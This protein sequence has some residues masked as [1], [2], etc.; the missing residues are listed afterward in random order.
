MH[1]GNPVI[2]VKMIVY[3]EPQPLAV[4]YPPPPIPMIWMQIERVQGIL[5]LDLDAWEIVL[6]GLVLLSVCSLTC[7]EPIVHMYF[8]MVIRFPI[9]PALVP[10]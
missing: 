6:E 8:S 10:H 4:I 2:Y 1:A 3:M 9:L 7:P 5:K